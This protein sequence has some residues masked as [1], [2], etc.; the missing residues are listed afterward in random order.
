MKLRISLVG[1]L[2]TFAAVTFAQPS[3]FKAYTTET[4]GF[5]NAFKYNSFKD[6]W[7]LQLG[8]GAQMMI[9]EDLRHR[10]F[11]PKEV[12]LAPTFAFGKWFTPWVAARLKAEGGPIH[13]TSQW[14][15]AAGG[16]WE[17]DPDFVQKD[18]YYAGHLDLMWNVCNWWRKYDS[19][20]FFSFIP[21]V[22]LG[23]YYREASDQALY[24][25]NT[26]P[27]TR[28]NPQEGRLASHN[29]ETGGFTI[30]GGFLLQFRLSNRIGLHVDL[31]GMLADDH[32]NRILWDAN[33]L[34]NKY[35]GV[36]AATAGLTFNFAKTYFEPIEPMD[37]NLIKEL[38]DK[39]NALRAENDALRNR[40]LPE[41]VEVPVVT[42][43]EKDHFLSNVFFRINKWVIDPNQQ[44]NVY[45]SAQFV[46]NTGKK[47]KVVG[48]ADRKTGNPKINIWL[49]EQRAKSVAK[50]LMTKYDIPSDM[51]IIE[52]RGDLEQPFAINN[53]NRVVIM[54]AAE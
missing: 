36:V 9:A 2:L 19:K 22:G 45:N 28:I 21:Y 49:G 34:H 42:V 17:I 54:T 47:I 3:G 27:S 6:N 51:I 39:I 31:S 20:R 43:V 10:F 26:S 18:Q 13:S 52:W 53:W 29:D 37:H 7:F 38:N 30:H 5:K 15:Q 23:F 11:E 24:S 25:D 33:R 1:L 41:P 50:E 16:E 14:R 8:C 32:F 46:K 35:E 48:Y 4:A 44:I 40:P 12:T